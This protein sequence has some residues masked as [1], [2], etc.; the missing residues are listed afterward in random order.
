MPYPNPV[1]SGRRLTVQVLNR[2]AILGS[3]SVYL[4][5][6]PG[7]RVREVA[8]DVAKSEATFE[9]AGLAQGVYGVRCGTTSQ[10]VLIER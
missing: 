4:H 1:G 6:A 5:D 7:R 10:R 9:L 8:L 3:A 2:P